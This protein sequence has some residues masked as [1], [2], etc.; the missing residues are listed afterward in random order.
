MNKENPVKYS[1]QLSTCE[2]IIDYSHSHK[3]SYQVACNIA[4]ANLKKHKSKVSS[5]FN[6]KSPCQFYSSFRRFK[7]MKMRSAF[8]SNHSP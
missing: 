8:I 5:G 6:L 4:F 1:L 3:V 7:S 2:A